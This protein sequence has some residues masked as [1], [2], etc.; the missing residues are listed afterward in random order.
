MIQFFSQL[1]FL[2]SLNDFT[3]SLKY[4]SL[5][6]VLRVI[7]G[8]C[9]ISPLMIFAPSFINLLINFLF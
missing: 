4:G 2:S 1:F 8:L 7:S 5:R 3:L 9:K 6:S